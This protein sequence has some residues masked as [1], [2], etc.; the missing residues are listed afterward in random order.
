MTQKPQ[1]NFE[2][3]GVISTNKHFLGGNGSLFWSGTRLMLVNLFP[4]SHLPA[5]FSGTMDKVFGPF[6]H[7]EPSSVRA[8]C[9]PEYAF[10]NCVTV[11]HD[12]G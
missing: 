5:G 4:V 8:P 7:S 2:I 6:F 11:F 9:K 12:F 10:C 3:I 1:T